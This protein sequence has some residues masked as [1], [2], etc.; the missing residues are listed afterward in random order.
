[1]ISDELLGGPRSV[2]IFFFV[3]VCERLA[4]IFDLEVWGNGAEFEG[5]DLDRTDKAR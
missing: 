5:M 4:E 3:E 1:L 2:I